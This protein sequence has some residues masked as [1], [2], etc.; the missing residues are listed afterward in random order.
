MNEQLCFVL[1]PFREDLKTVYTEAIKTACEQAGFKA[2]RA[3]ELI[4]PYNIHRDIIEYIFSSDAIVADL[5]DCN[6]NVFYELGVAHAIA[7]KT[8]MIMQK[9]QKPPFDIH[10]YRSIPYDL[11]AAGLRTLTGQIAE[12]LEHLAAWSKRPTNPVQEFKRDDVFITPEEAEK[13][14]RALRQKDELLKASALEAATPKAELEK[15]Q[16][17]H[18]ALQGKLRTQTQKTIAKTEWEALQKQLQAKIAENAALEKENARL[19]AK[20]EP[21][22]EARTTK[23]EKPKLLRDKPKQLSTDEVK[24]MLAEKGFYASDWNKAGKGIAHQYESK[25][26]N[27]GKVV[28][29]HATGLMWQQSGSS[30]YITFAAAEEYLREMNSQS[31]AGFN[32]WRL[33]TLEEAMSLME[34]EKKNGH[35]YI[36]PIFDDTQSWIWTGDKA[37][38]SSCWVAYFS[39]GYCGDQRAD[40]GNSARLVR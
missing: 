1:M 7:N 11:S 38:G 30:N 28:Q 27:G 31:F 12:Y 36:D 39:N 3:D 34:R 22:P 23:V 15:L 4:G 2:V 10:N 16:R 24:A 9:G 29:D 18:Q 33:P 17:E 6:P 25:T 26:I 35:L 37:G 5:T 21:K 20:A 14:R 40:H 8:I 19:R 13:L 32:D